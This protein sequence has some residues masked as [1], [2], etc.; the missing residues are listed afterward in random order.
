MYKVE[1]NPK[2]S[3][4]KIKVRALGNLKYSI[5]WDPVE[6]SQGYKIY[7]GFE[8]YYIRSLISPLPFITNTSFEFQFPNSIFP[9]MDIFFWV[10]YVDQNNE[11]IF[12]ND[13][14]INERDSQEI[15]IF[16]RDYDQ[17]G[18]HRTYIYDDMQYAFEEI[19]R[20]AFA[21]LQDIGEPVILF[22]KQYLGTPDNYVNQ[23]MLEDYDYNSMTRTNDTYGAGYFPGYFPG[24]EILMRF[25]GIP[26]FTFDF[27][28]TGLRP[29]LSTSEC[30]TLWDPYIRQFD[31]IYRKLSG[32]M[33]VIKS[34]AYSNIRGIRTIQ[35]F[36]TE[37]LNSNDPLNKITHEDLVQKWN[38]I[39]KLDFYR[40]GFGPLPGNGNIEDYMLFKF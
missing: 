37:L 16:N 12:I 6:G 33:Y 20:R 25:G 1:P 15:E 30:W 26:Q 31:L 3:S 40:I 36:D 7:A 22:K 17:Y 10:A 18:I 4:K 14:G 24:F 38:S 28:P 27:S 19:R 35:R 39:N 8:P 2:L 13:Y 5:S 11:T 21:V 23:D 32:K 34:A 9:D 29:I